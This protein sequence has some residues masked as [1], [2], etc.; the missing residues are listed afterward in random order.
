MLRS[1]IFSLCIDFI[2][3]YFPHVDDYTGKSK[4]FSSIPKFL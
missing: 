1:R 4:V 2:S 3:L